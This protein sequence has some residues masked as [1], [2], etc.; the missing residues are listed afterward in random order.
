MTNPYDQPERNPSMR[1]Q[2]TIWRDGEV[3]RS[4]AWGRVRVLPGVPAVPEQRA[5]AVV[6]GNKRGAL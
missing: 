3:I 5:K 2:T 6:G 4:D 1:Q